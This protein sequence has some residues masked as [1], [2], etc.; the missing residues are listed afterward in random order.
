MGFFLLGDYRIGLKFN[1]RHIPD[2][3]FKVYVS[4][5]M[6]EAHKLE[7]AQFPSGAVQADKPAQFMVR[8]NGAKGDLDAKV[9]SSFSMTSTQYSLSFPN[10]R[11]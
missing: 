4:P 11:S 7:I 1:D 5:A 6:G 2:S 9:G 8:K 3:P 10:L